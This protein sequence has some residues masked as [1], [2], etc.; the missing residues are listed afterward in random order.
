MD[1]YSLI[2]GQK[3]VIFIGWESFNKTCIPF[4]FVYNLFLFLQ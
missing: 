2:T 1:K 4:E 3:S